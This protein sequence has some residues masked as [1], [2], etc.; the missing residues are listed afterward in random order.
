MDI[1]KD[2]KIEMLKQMIL[3]RRFEEK[4]KVLYNE[5]LIPGAIHLCIGQ[6]AVA[7]G[8]C[9]A[10]KTSDYILSTHRGHGHA[11]A[12]GCDLNHIMAELFGKKTGLS[13]GHGGSMHLY[14]TSRGLMGGNGIV[15]GGIPLALGA[16]F[17]AQYRSTDQV[18]VAF[19]SD[20]AVNQGTF[21]ESLNLAA[22]FNLPVIF[23]CENNCYAATTPVS[24]STAKQDI[25]GRANCYGVSAVFVNGNDVIEVY[26]A[27]GKAVDHARLGKGPSFIECR[28]YRMEPHCGIIPDQRQKGEREAWREKDPLNMLKNVLIKDDLINEKDMELMEKEAENKIEKAVEYARNSPWPDIESEKNTSCLI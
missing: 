5:G 18:S 14:D 19:F 22:L 1:L 16:A 11:I 4:V 12:K 9:Q 21:G 27:V 6:E 15:G 17:S 25:T 13:G 10:L 2:Q 3:I 24:L 20:G 28:T 26:S 23:I 7:V 8:V